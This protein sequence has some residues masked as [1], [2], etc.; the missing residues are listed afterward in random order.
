MIVRACR[1]CSLSGSGYQT[2]SK[3]FRKNNANTVVIDAMNHNEERRRKEEKTSASIDL[4]S[5]YS[6][7]KYAN[8]LWDTKTHRK[9][10]TN[11]ILVKRTKTPTCELSAKAKTND[12]EHSPF[13]NRKS[14]C[15][16]P[17][18]GVLLQKDDD[19]RSP[20]CW[21]CLSNGGEA[22]LWRKTANATSQGQQWQQRL[23]WRNK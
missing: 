16:F 17:C 9:D 21:V 4:F 13:D 7:Q 8:P 12:N 15:C 10:L 6:N 18:R 14:T 5:Q 19:E 11:R 23:L 2:E 1:V 20:P 3:F 22:L